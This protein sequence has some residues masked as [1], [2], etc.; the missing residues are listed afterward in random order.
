M[1][2]SAG[3]DEGHEVGDLVCES[4][5]LVRVERELGRA[6][7]EQ[8][9][10]ALDVGLVLRALRGGADAQGLADRGVDVLGVVARMI[11]EE[12]GE[13]GRARGLD[14]GLEGVDDRVAVLGVADPEAD[15]RAAMG[16]DHQLEVEAEHLAV[17]EKT[18]IPV[19][20]PT[21]CAPGKYVSK[22]PRSA[23]SSGLRPGRRLGIRSPCSKS[24]ARIIA[25][26]KSR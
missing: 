2:E 10:G 1:V 13:R 4:S 7:G 20:S 17:D 25:V 18:S 21:H 19:P 24:S 22:A 5:R 9:E 23:S 14:A 26:E 15:P 11:V 3:E 8:A 12:Q 16:V 6:L